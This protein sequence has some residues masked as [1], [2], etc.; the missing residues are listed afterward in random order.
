MN[1]KPDQSGRAG[2]KEL[3]GK[4]HVLEQRVAQLESQK[5]QYYAPS[6]EDEIEHEGLSF[7]INVPGNGQL[8]SSI[9][10]Y[11]LAWLGNIVLFFGITFFV[12]Y[13]NVN[14]FKVISP[15]FGFASVSGIFLLAYYLR[16]PNPYMAKIFNLNGYLLVYYVT[17]KLHFFTAN[18]ILSGKPVGL[19]LLLI[20]TGVLM[21]L[22][23]RKK[24]TVLTGL[25]LIMISSTALVSDSTHVMLSLATLI[26]IFSIVFLYR[27]GWIRLVFLSIFLVYFTILLWLL[28][29]PLM[30]HQIQAI[31]DHHYGFIYLFFI[32][33]IFS[34][35]AL[36]PKK[37]ELYSDNSIIGSI[38]FNGLG[39]TFL[40]TL[41]ILS[42][43]K[44]NY[45]LLT[46]AIAFY[47]IVYSIILQLRSNWRITAALYALFGFVTLSVTIYG[48]YNFPHAYFLLA[49]QSLL[50]VSIA[51]WF[52]S[53][54]IVIM[55]SLLFIVLLMVYLATSGPG[56]GM[57]I[58]FTIVA[59]ATARVLN[60]KKERLTIRT[61]FI[62]NLYLII[63]FL[64]LLFTLYHLVPNQYI[65]LSWTVAAVL[66]FVFSVILKNVKYRYMALATMI[67]AALFLFIVDL[68]RIGLVY[69]V[70]ALLFLAIIS[71][72]LSFYYAKKL[73]KKVE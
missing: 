73:K 10:E 51:I 29:N 8:E 16:N 56:N 17:L 26:S 45:V 58:S 71:I 41:F 37:E 34:L 9:G 38:I 21:F 12:Q 69:R 24:N 5:R 55:N 64:M 53:K 7:N 54:F 72:G 27:F 30:G 50:V 42:F 33:A 1:S 52:R 60:W 2:Y 57:N 49:I 3:A 22:S 61:E 32:A 59:L 23:I 39:F 15:V 36:M 65:T 62:R 35:I 31:S 28:G 14:G 44:E 18:P 4:L 48:L 19:L 11:G 63:S 43:F 40:I 46:G 25:S 70:I 47:C 20:V 13:Q 6:E 67:A 68:A 66:Y